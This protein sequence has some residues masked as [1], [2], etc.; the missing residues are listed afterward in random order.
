MLD[1]REGPRFAV[2][3]VTTT[4]NAVLTTPVLLQELPVVAGDPFLPAA[5]ENA[6]DHIRELYWRRGY[7]D[8]TPD[9]ELAVEP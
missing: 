4:G 6:L 1:V 7:N 3:Q 9:Y 2:R 5:A 8:V